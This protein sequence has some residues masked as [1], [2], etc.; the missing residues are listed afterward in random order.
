[1]DDAHDTPLRLLSSVPGF[2]LGRS[3]HTA[4]F[5]PETT[6]RVVA[7]FDDRPTAMHREV[8]VHDTLRR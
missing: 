5:Q 4:P 8:V 2:G 6:V 3:D 1:V 7:P